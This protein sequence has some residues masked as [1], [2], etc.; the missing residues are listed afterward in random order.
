MQARIHEVIDREGIDSI[1][2]ADVCTIPQPFL[3]LKTEYKQTNISEKT[4]IIG[5]L[6]YIHKNIITNL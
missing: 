1:T 3:G 6:T 4:S 5:M 2:V